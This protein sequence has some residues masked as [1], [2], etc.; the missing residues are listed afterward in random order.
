MRGRS[1]ELS[2]ATGSCRS[3][4]WPVCTTMANKITL[5]PLGTRKLN[6]AKHLPEAQQSSQARLPFQNYFP[7]DRLYLYTSQ[8][9]MCM[10]CFSGLVVGCRSATRVGSETRELVS[11]CCNFEWKIFG[12]ISHSTA[13]DVIQGIRSE[14]PKLSSI[15]VCCSNPVVR[16]IGE[17]WHGA[18]ACSWIIS[19]LPIENLQSASHAKITI[20]NH[21]TPIVLILQIHFVSL[22]L[23]PD[24]H[25]GILTRYFS[26]PV[27]KNS[28]LA[29]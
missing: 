11:P 17:H 5:L 15:D 29:D 14:P 8:T 27:C 4:S 6:S 28:W 12:Q 25:L 13:C 18:K 21:E 2:L 24:Q 16:V 10:M 22:I 19:P 20:R 3:L 1:N 7:G 23:W 26:L 9:A